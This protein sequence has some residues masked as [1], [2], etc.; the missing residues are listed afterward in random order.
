MP[1]KEGGARHMYRQYTQKMPK[2][3]PIKTKKSKASHNKEH[4]RN[5]K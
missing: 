1:K 2:Q 5:S 4:L 3:A